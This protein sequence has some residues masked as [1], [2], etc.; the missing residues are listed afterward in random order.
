LPDGI[1]TVKSVLSDV[2][3]MATYGDTHGGKFGKAASILFKWQLKGDK[4]AAQE[5]LQP[6]TLKADGWEIVAK[7]WGGAARTLANI[8]TEA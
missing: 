2:G 7:G 4:A 6:T 5:F 3:H 1:P 8:T